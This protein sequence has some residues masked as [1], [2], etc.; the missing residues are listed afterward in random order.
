[1]RY[2]V[3]AAL[4]TLWLLAMPS[5]V[6]AQ[7]GIDW[8]SGDYPTYQVMAVEFAVTTGVGLGIFAFFPDWGHQA[9]R[10]ARQSTV[11]SFVVGIPGVLSIWV[12]WLASLALIATVVGMIVGV[13]L[14]VFSFV[15]DVVWET[16]GYVAVGT[17]LGARLW[18]DNVWLGCF[19]GGVLSAVLVPIPYLGT[20]IGIL[21]AMLGIGASLRV[22]LGAG[23]VDSRERSVPPAHRT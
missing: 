16:V 13:P 23:G 4:A 17:V 8:I 18:T 2:K 11:F 22:T 21:V 19:V 1:M 15:F 7:T 5:V 12:L 9:V 20:L 10:T 3:I 14:A 6:A